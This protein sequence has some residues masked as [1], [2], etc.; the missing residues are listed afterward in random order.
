MIKLFQALKKTAT[1]EKVCKVTDSN[2]SR[3]HYLKIMCQVVQQLLNQRLTV[4]ILKPIDH[5]TLVPLV[6]RNVQ[7]AQDTQFKS[8]T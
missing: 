6:E 8:L 3:I 5:H 1:T 2:L 7:D 4:L